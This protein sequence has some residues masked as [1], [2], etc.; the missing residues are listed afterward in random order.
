MSW[1]RGPARRWPSPSART[2]WSSPATPASG[3][4]DPA[5][6]C[7]ATRP[8]PVTRWRPPSLGALAHG[9]PW[10]DAVVDAVALS[11]AAV[12]APYAGEVDARR[13][14]AAPVVGEPRAAG[15][16][17]MTLVS[18]S[19]LLAD[20]VAR[21]TGLF[22]FNVITLEHAEGILA[23]AARAGDRRGAAGERER[24]RLPRRRRRAPAARLRPAGRHACRRG[25]AAPRPPQR[26]GPARPRRARDRAGRQLGDV[27]RQPGGLRDERR[28]HPPRSAER[29]HDRG[30]LVEAELGEV[31]GKGGA[32]APG[33]RTDP[34]EAAEFVA[35]TGV[36]A[37]AVAVGSSHAMSEQTAQPRP[38]ADRPHSPTPCRCRSS[39]TAPR[40]CLGRSCAPPW[41]PASGRSTSAPPSTSPSPMRCEESWRPSRSWSTRAAT[42]ARRARP[43]PTSSSRC[44]REVLG[45]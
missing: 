19:G 22:A 41:R 45:P 35:A 21:E 6:S 13:G 18:T 24:R 44:S 34:G 1:R 29:L 9:I 14:R 8:G 17:R 33:V 38:R 43:S 30:L 32:H 27:R 10:A 11:A 39:S 36:D 26:H 23:G 15:R 2:A 5:T 25:V 28:A 40:V 37:L 3:S 7:M 20:A 4:R 12:L 16:D 42:F 31:G